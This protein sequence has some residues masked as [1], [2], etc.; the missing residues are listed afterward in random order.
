MEKIKFV[1]LFFSLFIL[2][3]CPN[4]ITPAKPSILVNSTNLGAIRINNVNATS[5]PGENGVIYFSRHLDESDL[6]TA[7]VAA[8][9]TLRDDAQKIRA[10]N[11]LWAGNRY[12]FQGLLTKQI[13]AGFSLRRRITTQ[14]GTTSSDIPFQ[15]Q[16]KNRGVERET[17]PANEFRYN[18]YAESICRNAT[19]RSLNIP[20]QPCASQTPTQESAIVI[21]I[22]IPYSTLPIHGQEFEFELVETGTGQYSNLEEISVFKAIY[23]ERGTNLVTPRV[24][25]SNARP[26]VGATIDVTV[27]PPPFA[28][29]VSSSVIGGI[30]QSEKVASGVNFTSPVSFQLNVGSQVGQKSITIQACDAMKESG[31]N[32]SGLSTTFIQVVN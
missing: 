30:Y 20:N 19:L 28:K 7:A 5:W 24:F 32:R 25:V 10:A 18:Y 21:T 15:N 4:S 14:T 11:D 2:T 26:R 12:S 17:P 23:V 16:F 31:S 29:E 27:Y 3:S 8:D 22:S 1:L 6:S 9:S 13:G